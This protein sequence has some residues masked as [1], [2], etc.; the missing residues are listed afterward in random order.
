M[1]MT[2]QLMLEQEMSSGFGDS[3]E[4]IAQYYVLDED[5]DCELIKEEVF[6]FPDGLTLP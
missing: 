4:V 3:A 1:M 5:H 6:T 2:T